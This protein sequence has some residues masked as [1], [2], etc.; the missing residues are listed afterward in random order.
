MKK[1]IASLLIACATSVTASDW[2]IHG[3]FGMNPSVTFH[4][5]DPSGTTIETVVLMYGVDSTWTFLWDGWAISYGD[6]YSSFTNGS[7]LTWSSDFSTT[8]IVDDGIHGAA[9]PLRWAI[10][11]G[12]PDFNPPADPLGWTSSSAPETPGEYWID[13]GQ[14]QHIRIE[15][16]QPPDFG[17]WDWD[18]SVNPSWVEPLAKKGHGKGHK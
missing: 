7:V 3:A 4:R 13:F 1:I 14:D 10:E 5:V 17:K 15:N 18:G 16:S 8:G 9:S 2:V 11:G 6:D 12:P